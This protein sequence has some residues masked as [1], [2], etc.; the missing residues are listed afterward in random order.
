MRTIKRLGPGKYEI[1]FLGH[2]VFLHI[3]FPDRKGFSQEVTDKKIYLRAIKL[4]DLTPM[5]VL[6]GETFN[7]LVMDSVFG[8]T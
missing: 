2:K 5:T 4:F 3:T 7:S 8:R 6:D 1:E